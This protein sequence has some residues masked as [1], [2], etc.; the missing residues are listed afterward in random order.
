MMKSGGNKAIEHIYTQKIIQKG[1][2]QQR[3]L[4]IR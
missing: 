3:K 2:D 1:S 4:K